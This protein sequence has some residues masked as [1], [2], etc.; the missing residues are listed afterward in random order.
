MGLILRVINGSTARRVKSSWLE[1]GELGVESD[2]VLC[3]VQPRTRL[4]YKSWSLAPALPAVQDG[5]SEI[6]EPAPC[7]RWKRLA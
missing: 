3:I 1:G 6:E 2:R 7:C 4:S 5:P